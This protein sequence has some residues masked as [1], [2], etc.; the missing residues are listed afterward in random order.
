MTGQRYESMPVAWSLPAIQGEVFT[1]AKG[2]LA[3]LAAL[4]RER[5]RMHADLVHAPARRRT[6]PDRIARALPAT[7]TCPR[8]GTRLAYGCE[9]HPLTQENP[10]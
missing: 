7:G 1:T 2:D 8:C 3:F 5:A 4:K 9:H 10:A 6:S